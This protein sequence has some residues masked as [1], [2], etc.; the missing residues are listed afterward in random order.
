[1]D[2]DDRMAGFECRG[3][4]LGG[5]V[6]AGRRQLGVVGGVRVDRPRLLGGRAEVD[7]R[8]EVGSFGVRP[9]RVAADRGISTAWRIDARGGR[10]R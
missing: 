10:W 4:E 2:A 5:A 6:V 9:D 3:V 7:R 1:M 8:L